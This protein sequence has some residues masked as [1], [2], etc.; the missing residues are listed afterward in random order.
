MGRANKIIAKGAVVLG[1]L[2]LATIVVS[3][4]ISRPQFDERLDLATL[5]NITIAP[6]N[7][8]L[9][10]ARFH[11]GEHLRILLVT[12]YQNGKVTGF[13]TYRHIGV[14]ESDPIALFNRLGYAALERAAASGAMQETVDVAALDLPFTTRM[15]NIGIGTNYR[16]HARE[17]RVAETPFVFPKRVLPSL[18]TATVARRDSRLLDYEAELGFVALQDLSA[19]S[20]PQAMGLVLGNDFTDR[21]SL[22]QNLSR[23][24][25]MG[26]TGF[27]EGK[28]REG[29][30]P[31]GGLLVIP[32]NLDSFY[33]EVELKL[34]LNG[35]LRQHDKAGSM[36][37]GPQEMLQE[38]FAREAWTFR[39]YQDSVP[40]L[41]QPG[42]IPAGTIIFSG[43]PAGVLFKP[44]NLWNHWAYLQ[45]GDEVIMRAEYLGSLRNQ[46]VD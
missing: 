37:W 17:S 18:P 27:V 30:A 46:V 12:K 13:N 1:L 33:R 39:H 32:K 4:A 21:W 6:P 24:T 42:V 40:L 25:E 16:E 9:T 35:R 29:Y 20:R 10:F 3:L 7:Q 28:S 44:L 43:T 38:V 8:A 11:E 31:I 34:Y 15:A 41:E 26:T 19:Q 2:L 36:S 22:V 14:N 23:E 45:P 5:G